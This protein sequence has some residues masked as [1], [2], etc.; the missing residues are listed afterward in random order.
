M[1]ALSFKNEEAR[2]VVQVPWCHRGT[3]PKMRQYAPDQER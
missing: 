3:L 2:A 1:C